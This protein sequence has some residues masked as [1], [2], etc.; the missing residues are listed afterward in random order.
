MKNL[1]IVFVVL[2][3]GGCAFGVVD[4]SNDERHKEILASCFSTKKPAFLYEARC[5]DLNAGGFGNSTFCTGIQGFNPE[6]YKGEHHIYHYKYPKSWAE[7]LNSRKSWDE[8]LFLKLLF[9]KQRSIIAP[10]EVGTKM[11]ISGI[12]EYPRGETGH[13][14][15]VR[16]ILTSGEFNGTEVELPSPGR[17]SD[18]GPNW[19]SQRFYEPNKGIELSDEYLQRCG[20]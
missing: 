19:T 6:P 2:F 7:Y 14:L 1:A 18:T 12:Y 17:F 13:V 8:T 11:R 16:A 3:L 15:I 5:A 10:I 20:N 4:H 9:E